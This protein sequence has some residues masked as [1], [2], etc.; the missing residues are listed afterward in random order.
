[1]KGQFR[2]KVTV[3][4]FIKFIDHEI[5]LFIHKRQ[6]QR[7]Q[8]SVCLVAMVTII[9]C[10]GP[11]LIKTEGHHYGTFHGPSFTDFKALLNKVQEICSGLSVFLLSSQ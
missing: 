3:L 11:A 7:E 4:L 10:E 8:E 5:F 9:H 1:L 2:I 6:R